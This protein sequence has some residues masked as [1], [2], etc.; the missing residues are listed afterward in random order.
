MRITRTIQRFVRTAAVLLCALLLVA[1][2]G[3]DEAYNER[4]EWRG[5]SWVPYQR[6]HIFM[7]LESPEVLPPA[8]ATPIPSPKTIAIRL[9]DGPEAP[10]I[11]ELYAGYPPI[12]IINQSPPSPWVRLRDDVKRTLTGLGYEVL[13]FTE[14]SDDTSSVIEA[15]MIL[16]DTRSDPGGLFDVKGTT[17]G[18]AKF[19]I[20]LFG[21]GGERLWFR[22]F[23]GH[24]EI[25]VSY[26][27]LRGSKTTL[28]EAYAHALE[29]FAHVAGTP[30]F[31]SL[32]E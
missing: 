25:K 21:V 11:G 10:K 32:V 28:G 8:D 5:G 1:C 27:F 13:E 3:F 18:Y 24:H 19:R 31:Y 12:H 16:L 22:E 15:D 20:T 26:F 29:D 17:W 2:E 14:S 30:E 4:V 9:V 6:E 23:S 7:P